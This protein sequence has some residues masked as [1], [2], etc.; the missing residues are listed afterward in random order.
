MAQTV[1]ESAM[2]ETQICS[3]S[4]EDLLEKRMLP[5]RVFLPGEIHEQR[6]LAGYSPWGHK[7]SDMTE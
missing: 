7:E 1:K 2:L 4:Q 6:R 3:L 5:T